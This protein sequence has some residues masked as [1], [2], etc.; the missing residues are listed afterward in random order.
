MNNERVYLDVLQ[1]TFFNGESRPDRTGTGTLSIFGEQTKYDISEYAPVLTTKFVPWKSC[2]KELLWFLRGETDAKILRDQGV[3]IWDANSSRE[4]LDKRGL[5][6]LPEGDIGSGY[7][8]NWRHFG[9]QYNTCNDDYTGE[10][11]DQ[12][13]YICNTLKTDPYS[14]RIFLSAW[15]PAVMETTALPPCHL[16]A[17]FYVSADKQLS[18]HM[19]QRSNDQFLGQPWNMLSYTALTYLFA[20]KCE[21]SPKELIISCGDSHIYKDHLKQVEELLCRT[22]YKPPKLVVSD[23]VIVKEWKDITIDDFDLQDY[24]YHPAI[25]ANMSA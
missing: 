11:F 6:H 21:M 7:G 16:S 12:I 19:Y 8:F 24:V 1:K 4:F 10:G 23:D 17:Q 22:P 20:K 18:C 9:A 3:K 5:Q 25:K 13:E 15:N 2:I 14:R